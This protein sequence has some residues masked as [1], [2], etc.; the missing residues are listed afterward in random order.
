MQ[1]AIATS[2]TPTLQGMV[3]FDDNGDMKSHTVSVFQIREDKS[4]P[5]DDMIAQYHYLG[6]APQV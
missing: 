2:K 4:K 1:A 5:L 3:A 6:T